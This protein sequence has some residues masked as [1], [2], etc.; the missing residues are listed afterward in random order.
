MK[1]MQM[2][3]AV[4][5]SALSVGF[6]AM[7]IWCLR[8]NCRVCELE[9]ARADAI[10]CAKT[11]A[12]A[13]ASEKAKAPVCRPSEAQQTTSVTNRPSQME[14]VEVS[15][16][17]DARLK[18]RL[19][20]RP[21]MEAVRSYVSVGPMAEGRPVF[22]Y[23]TSYSYSRHRYEPVL[24]V[25]GEFA[26]RT[27]VT[28][29]IRRGLP[30]YGKGRNPAATG[31]LKAD[32]TFDFR[33]KDRNPYVAYAADGRYL[34]PGGKRAVEI[35]SMN[36]TN[37]IYGIRRVEPRNVV[38]MLAREECVYR[39]SWYGGTADAGETEELSG[40]PMTNVFSCAAR[41]NAK[42]V[43]PLTVAMDDGRWTN[44]IYLVSIRNGD[45]PFCDNRWEQEWVYNPDIYRVVCLSDLGVSVRK[46]GADNLCVWVTSLTKGRPVGEA[47]VEVYSAA[48]VKVMEGRT[49]AQGLCRATR[50]DRGEPFAVVVISP[51]GSDMTFMAIRDS[52]CVD[53]TY[54]SGARSAYLEDGEAEAFLWT[55]R[56]IY[57][58]DERIFLHAILRDGKCRAPKPFPVELRLVGP[59]GDALAHTTRL[60]DAEG[61]LAYQEFVVPADQ[62]SGMWSLL[63]KLPGKDGREL[64]SRAVKIEEFA[65]PQIRV[66]VAP[67]ATVHPSNFTFAVSAEHLFGGPAHGLRCEGAVVFEDVPFAP[68]DWKGWHFGNDDRGLKPSYREL[69]GRRL[70][71]EGKTLFFAPIFAD[72]GLPKAAVRATAQGVVF[73]DGGRPATMRKSVVSHYYPYYIGSTLPSWLKLEHGQRPKVA[74]ACVGTDGRPFAKS[75]RLV[76]TLERIDSV[77]T[78]RKLENGWNTWDCEHVRVKVAEG[79]Q[80]V[81]SAD[82]RA[83]LELPVT[84]S[85]DYAL[86]VADEDAS[87]GVSFG[88]SFYLSD[89]GDDVVRAPLAN[90]TSVVLMP[91]KAF[92][93]VGESPRLT[94][95]SPFA[96]WALLSVMRDKEVY[97]EAFA[98][99]NVTSEVVLRPVQTENAPNLDVYVSVVQSV[100]EN[101][102]HLA[103]RAHGQTTVAIRPIENEIPV[104]VAAEV[105]DL[106][107]IDV[108]LDAPGADYAVVT[109]VDE[110]I[111]LLTGEATPDPVGYFAK[112]RG[113]EHPLYDLYHRILPVVGGESLRANG[114]KT[115][116]G[117]GAEMLGRVSPTPT[118]RFKPLALWSAKVAVRDG[119][120]AESIQI[121]EFVGEVRVTAVAYSAR[122]TGAASVQKKVTPKLVMMPDAPR[123][124]APGDDFEI[125]LPVYNRSGVAA[126]FDFAISCG[127]KPVAG[128]AQVVLPVDGSTNIV[129]RLKAAGELGEMDLRYEVRGMGEDHCQTIHLPVR[130]AVAW[131]EEVGVERCADTAKFETRAKGGRGERF[132][133]KVFD[134][135]AGE[136]SRALEWLADYPHGCLEQTASRIFPL[137]SAGGILTA[138]DSGKAANRA[139]YVAA[140]VKRVESMVRE[141]DFVMWPDCTYAPW[142]KEVSLYAAHFLVEAERAGQKLDSSA[143][144][145]V[146]GFLKKWAM[147]TN[148]TVSAYAC[149]T[150]AIA[151]SSEKDRMFDLYDRRATLSLLSRARLARAFAAI[152]DR[153][154]M[155]ALLAN[156]ASPASVKE[157]AFAVMALLELNPDDARILPLVN[158]LNA[159]RDRQRFCW[160]TTE[161]NAHA[162]LAI[163][164]YYRHRPPAKGE[165]FVV[166]REL[167]LP[168]VATVRDETNGLSVTRRFLTPEGRPVETNVFARGEMLIAELTVTAADSR[169]LSDLVVEDLFAGAIEPIH[170]AAPELPLG[171]NAVAPRAWVMRSDA[172]DDRMLVFSKKFRLARG[173]EAKFRYPV[174]VVSAG[175]YIL[176]GPSVEAMYFPA[177][178]S[179]RAPT[180]IVIS[181]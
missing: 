172:R 162:L 159:A 144:K 179:R 104:K 114:V 33:R 127:G 81:T 136:L 67:D 78:Y 129:A 146:V 26:Y 145:R 166:W 64:G 84:Q 150:L 140:G 74:L 16:D 155:E 157:A 12:C 39:R 92:Y 38:Q 168:D 47:R 169:E 63:A 132:A 62:P 5:V 105:R 30:L 108:S 28:L 113:E 58:H 53:E 36:V 77:Y 8:L 49:D 46:S 15:Y 141:N 153:Q 102:R 79:L 170:G 94:V 135:P 160:G 95:K 1:T 9:R 111:N 18:V 71:R 66:A 175:D 173:Q 147:S 73:E 24:V 103:V 134:S 21:D 106:K 165:K 86:T 97:T 19:S 72:S 88:K 54:E 167:S 161:E 34:P 61:A 45:R 96:G 154:R 10:A 101:A 164:A 93:R 130:P 44:G 138:V 181:K 3:M 56:G 25:S 109:V 117:F 178:K 32:F 69:D 57:R 4:L 122:A 11:N 20:E 100:G 60:P 41:A 22:E 14:V 17:G 115:G 90:P 43:H 48:N 68:A 13:A 143:R 6:M 31:S 110:A 156:V 40:E 2:K 177:L 37:V 121:P 83:T 27:N 142:D 139:E 123:F 99:T 180:R 119:K 137:I 120:G 133:Y 107:K 52:M 85:G 118:R 174:R 158:Y 55:D 50:V 131:Q 51:D 152:D 149:H 163:G 42:E 59:S 75:R 80:V 87:T 82:G 29:R 171:T 176:P 7:S 70:D 148:T 89:W 91:N 125:S 65:P 112:L 76:A 23:R 151:G 126:K 116:G 128:S 98:L 35:E 124:V